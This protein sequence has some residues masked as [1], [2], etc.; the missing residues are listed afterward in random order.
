MCVFIFEYIYIYMYIILFI[1]TYFLY[2]YIY[3][4]IYISASKIGWVHLKMVGISPHCDLSNSL[5]RV[6]PATRERVILQV[7]NSPCRG[8]AKTWLVLKTW[9]LRR[10]QFLCSIVFL[11]QTGLKRRHRFHSDRDVNLN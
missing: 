10:R 11:E 8:P 3:L 9:L 2:L 1:H 4:F 7:A 5:W 6:P